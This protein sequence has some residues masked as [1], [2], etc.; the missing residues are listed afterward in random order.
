VWV[1]A[2]IMKTFEKSILP[3]FTI[4][5]PNLNGGC[6][7]E[8]TV[9]SVL[10]QGYPNLEYFVVDGAS[11]DNSLEIIKKHESQLANWISEPDKGMY[12]A[13]NKG[14]SNSHGEVMAYLNS[15]DLYAPWTLNLVG[16]VF[17]RF[18]QIEWL[19]T[20]FPSYWDGNAN[21]VLTARV[22]G[23]NRKWV[24]EGHYLPYSG[25]SIIQ[26][27]TTFWRRSLWEKAGGYMDGKFRLAG[28]AELWLRFA[29]YAEPYC[30]EAVL[31]GFRVHKTQQTKVHAG[32]LM[33][34]AKQLAIRHKIKPHR[35][36][37]FWR[38]L[39]SR[40]H[41][42]L[43]AKV[44]KHLRIFEK[45]SIVRYDIDRLEWVIETI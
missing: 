27:E 7:L 2:N 17:L 14:F 26:Q 32:R 37:G 21:L 1:V 5:T 12:D 23:V 42:R 25:S 18:P 30:I 39:Q 3:T 35:I 40:L 6:Y 22:G 19:T 10:N 4:V 20:N 8:Q 31:G 36:S 41:W 15:D 28:D 16:E 38:S 24:R 11:T 44:N 34:E 45:I 9:Q 33:D 29:K 13:I 43:R